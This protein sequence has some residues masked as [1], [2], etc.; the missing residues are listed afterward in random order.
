MKRVDFELEFA[1]E[2]IGFEVEGLV[3]LRLWS[4]RDMW[5]RFGAVEAASVG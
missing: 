5:R 1:E 2:E 4:G 3:L